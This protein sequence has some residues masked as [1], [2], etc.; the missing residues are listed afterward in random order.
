MCAPLVINV[1]ISIKNIQNST[2]QVVTTSMHLYTVF[3]S[4]GVEVLYS[5]TFS[6]YAR[7]CS[8]TIVMQ[9]TVLT[10]SDTIVMQFT[11]LTCSDTIVMQF[12]V[13]IYML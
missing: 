8:G 9:F 6:M 4:I 3:Q 12:T 10:C 1:K 5:N 13:L 11:V 7:T 2:T